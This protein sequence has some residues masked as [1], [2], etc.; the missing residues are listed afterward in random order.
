MNTFGLSINRWP[1]LWAVTFGL[2]LT[3][4]VFRCVCG[5]CRGFCFI[6]FRFLFFLIPEGLLHS[7]DLFSSCPS[8]FDT[9]RWA[10][11]VVNNRVWNLL[12]PICLFC[13]KLSNE[14]AEFS[15]TCHNCSVDITTPMIDS[16]NSLC[17]SPD[18]RQGSWD[19]NLMVADGLFDFFI[20]F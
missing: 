4:Y 18:V 8:L 6:Q 12:S 7:Y 9:V 16:L 5:V 19:G 3:A 14:L 17:A 20:V 11:K 15:D 1:I 2:G 10:V 13:L